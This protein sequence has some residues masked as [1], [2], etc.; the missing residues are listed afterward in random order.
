MLSNG[1][2]SVYFAG[3][4]G[5]CDDFKEIGQKFKEI[6]LALIPIGAYEPRHIMKNQHINPEEAIQ[7]YI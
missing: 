3:D 5:Y 4:T 1:E 6:D 2:K 7:V